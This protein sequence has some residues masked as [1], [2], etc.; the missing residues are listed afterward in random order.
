VRRKF[1]GK[2]RLAVGPSSRAVQYVRIR[3][4]RRI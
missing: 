1:L 3:T 4:N 2:E